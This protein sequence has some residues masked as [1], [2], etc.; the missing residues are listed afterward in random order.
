[1]RLRHTY[2]KRTVALIIAFIGVVVYALFMPMAIPEDGTVF[3][4][5]PG[6]SRANLVQELA[7]NKCIRFTPIFG[8]FTLLR[9]KVPQ[10]G[11]Y[12]FTRWSSPY[13]M[14]KQIIT[15]KG[16]Y[17]RAF[18]IIPGTT[19]KQIKATLQDE[20]TF[21]HLITEMSDK[22][23]MEM[24]GDATHAPEGMFLPE[25]YYYS[26]GDSDLVMLKRAYDLMA[27]KLKEAWDGR[28][29]DL[30]YKDAYHALIAASLIEEE[31]YLSK[32]QSVIGGVL[33]NRL[34]I[35][36]PLQFDP[37]VIYGMGD[38]Y[39]GKI[40]K[41]DLTTDTPYNSYLHTGLPPTPISMPGLSA[42]NAAMHPDQHGY[43]YFVAAGDGSHTFTTNL[44][45]HKE[46]VLRLRETTQPSTVTG[47][48]NVES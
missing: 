7:K 32:E 6:I 25:T 41:T 33:V 36:M 15:G 18:T 37:T 44:Q 42:I 46:A 43:L 8:A 27:S 30:P 47:A 19:F 16:R 14:W 45:D 24:L 34:R 9:G 40:F 22:E 4:V 38:A 26:R 12:L 21:K 39:Q 23:V 17:Y 1:M 29:K 35:N 13:T 11:E 28:D 2:L 48:A 3:Y 20:T 10:S 5:Q 31:A